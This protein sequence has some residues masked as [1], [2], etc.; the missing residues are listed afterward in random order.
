MLV[1]NTPQGAHYTLCK[2]ILV[3]ISTPTAVDLS[4][5]ELKIPS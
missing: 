4:I 1:D 2:V 5:P 3:C